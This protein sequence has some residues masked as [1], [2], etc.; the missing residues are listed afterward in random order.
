VNLGRTTLNGT[1]VDG[2]RRAVRDLERTKRAKDKIELGLI[3]YVAALHRSVEYG[4]P[5]KARL[6]SKEV[7]PIVRRVT[8]NA[9]SAYFAG[10][11]DEAARF[12][13]R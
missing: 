13:G 9:L 2:L 1:H 4:E 5:T 11:P 3:A 10:H 7:A 8:A 12:N 6:V